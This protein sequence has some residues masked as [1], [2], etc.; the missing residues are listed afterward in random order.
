MTLG[1]LT[2]KRSTIASFPVRNPATARPWPTTRIVTSAFSLAAVFFPQ[3]L[4]LL[5][6]GNGTASPGPN[7]PSPPRLPACG[8]AYD[9]DR[10]VIVLFGGSSD[11]GTLADTW[12]YDGAAWTQRTLSPSPSLRHSFGM[13]YDSARHRTLLFGGTPNSGSLAD[14]WEYDG[15]AWTQRTAPGVPGRSGCAMAYDAVHQHTVLH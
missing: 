8:M 9:S 3:A 6:P 4:V 13:V 5:Q 14:T 12:E 1:R 2:G 10:H 15:T 11:S 7:A